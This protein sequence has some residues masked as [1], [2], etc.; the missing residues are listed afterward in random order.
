MSRDTALLGRP[1]GWRPKCLLPAF[2]I[3]DRA[4]QRDGSYVV[5]R[6]LGQEDRAAAG[7]L[8]DAMLAA[9]EPGTYHP[10]GHRRLVLL[11]R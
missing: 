7:A 10:H 9:A 5:L 3:E 11:R 4:M 1:P 2:A 6:E 8:F